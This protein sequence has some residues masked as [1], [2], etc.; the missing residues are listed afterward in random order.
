MFRRCWKLLKILLQVVGI[1]SLVVLLFVVS[2]FF[3]EQSVPADWVESALDR[4]APRDFVIRL[5]SCAF[6]LRRGVVVTGLRVYE[7]ARPAP[8]PLFASADLVI[9]DYLDRHLYV[10]GA[11]Y[12]KLPDSYYEPV[13]VERRTPVEATFPR[14][15]RYT[16]TL[17]RPDILR[18]APEKVIADV[19]VTPRRLSFERVHLDWKLGP[20]GPMSLEGFC[21]VDLDRQ[22][23]CGEVRGTAVQRDI[24]PFLDA[25]DIPVS[26]PY[27][28]AFTEV[29]GVVP[30]SCAWRV[31]LTNND[32]KLDLGLHP[33][34]GRYNGVKMTRA[35]GDLHLDV[36]TRGNHLNYHHVFGPI[37]GVGPKG[38]PLEGTVT[39][40]GK[41]GYNTVSVTARSALPVADL[42]KIG[43][44]TGD[45]VGEDVVG[46]SECD[47]EFRFPRAMTNNYEL[48]N[49]KGRLSV[50]NGHLMRMKG[51]NGLIEQLADRAPGVSWF[52]DVTQ[53]S[54]D[55]V[56]ENGVIKSD[57]IYIEGSVFSIKM[58]GK[59]DAA[60]DKL[61]FTA[62]VQFTKKDSFAGKILHP[63]TWPFTKL[64]LEFRLTGSPDNPKWDYISVIDRVM[65]GN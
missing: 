3:R 34:L 53:G 16:L 45:Y 28:D 35:D 46:E 56:I 60:H 23:V 29:P 9:F 19:V 7:R 24:R 8:R 6:G 22:E 42:L 41:N 62:R 26:L 65:G 5:D 64:L 17:V 1:A 61:D 10:E 63:L 43:G 13:N 21:F 47:L 14:I 59:F 15:P 38:E 30:A 57:N 51:F 52:T 50:K 55:Y 36:Y 20:E 44:F 18:A 11:R 49:G 40:D 54:C 12:S 33:T 4:F 31:D 37:V 39:V 32:L 2:L 27:V 25:L 58:F 48:L